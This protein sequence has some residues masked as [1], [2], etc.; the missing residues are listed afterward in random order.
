[1]ILKKDF[2]GAAK[3]FLFFGEFRELERVIVEQQ[4]EIEALKV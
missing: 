4:K 1:L 3:A 2:K